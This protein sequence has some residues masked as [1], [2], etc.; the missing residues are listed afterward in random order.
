M[1]PKSSEP[2]KKKWKKDKLFL[3][4]LRWNSNT[5]KKN[6]FNDIW[7]TT[8][9]EFGLVTNAYLEEASIFVARVYYVVNG[10]G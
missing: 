7:S 2:N 10:K 9:E 6:K 8:K 1:E 4:F 5:L 3:L